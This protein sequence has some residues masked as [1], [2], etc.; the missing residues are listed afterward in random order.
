MKC[1]KNIGILAIALFSFFYTEKIANLTLEKNEIYQE[2]KSEADNYLVSA[3][4]ATINGDYIIPGLNG[5]KVA[6]KDSYYNMKD[7]NTFNSYYLVFDTTYPK[8][9]LDFNKDKII[10]N[11]NAIKR[12]VAFVLEYNS[13]LIDYFK[14]HNY[15]AS[16]LVNKENFSKKETLEQINNEVKDFSGLESLINKY[17][18]N[19]H[20]CYLN[21]NNDELCHKNGNYLVKSNKILNNTSFIE[22]KNNIN[23]GDI[24]YVDK[25]MDVKNIQ[26]IINNILYKDLDIVKLSTLISEERD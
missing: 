3:V 10:T 11:G 18:N 5:K 19:S 4:S 23:S 24:Y 14:S 6:I 9:S 22:I 25:N 26:L 2:I 7:L 1:F 13:N 16:V 15:E 12:S 21:G 20:I 8:E 17:S